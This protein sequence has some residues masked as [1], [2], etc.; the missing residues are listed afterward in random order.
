MQRGE[1]E[2]LIESGE[3]IALSFARRVSSAYINERA[4]VERMA[5]MA[6]SEGGTLLVGV[7]SDGTVSGA[8]PFHGDHT[9]PVELAAAVRRHTSPPLDVT[10]EVAAVGGRAVVALS[11]E[12]AA[13]PVA[14]TWGVYRA[15]RLNGAG[16]AVDE[17]LTPPELFTRY[18]D[19][20]GLD[21]ALSPAPGATLADLD[22][23]AFA[24]Y[25]RL[26]SAHHGNTAL[27]A[28][29][30]DAL[31]RALGFRN[32]SDTPILLGA[33]AL[34]G[35][36]EA[37]ARHLPYHQV[38]LAD[39]RAPRTTWRSRAPLAVLA[40][41]L[42]ASEAVGDALPFV[43]NALAH[44]DYSLP[45]AVYVHVDAKRRAVTS[46]GALPRGVRP[47]DLLSDAPTF[48]P[49]SLYLSTALAHTGLTRGAG[50]GVVD[51]ARDLARRGA[52]VPSYA[53]THAQAV[54]VS[55]VSPVGAGGASTSDLVLEALRELG[56]AS[57]GEVA[58]RAGLGQQQA[59][60]ALRSLVGQGRVRR[61]GATRTTRY[62]AGV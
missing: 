32:D 29:D 27:A 61:S 6:N 22:P 30:D 62:S 28:R 42:A 31:V 44:R 18:R 4:V 51:A 47:E 24:A 37:L 2:Q 1:I 56:E 43:L 3:G 54:T 35:T 16:V 34:F 45:G 21:W 23:A 9:D 19:A 46:P 58:R 7:D 52:P 40:E 10:V 14:T 59:Y 12:A 11:T 5:A 60:R 49:R 26:T 48:A 39:T 13:S 20:N 41:N 36:E 38:V 55:V 57:S 17:G 53:G 50:T 33:V 15:R 25:R 8:H